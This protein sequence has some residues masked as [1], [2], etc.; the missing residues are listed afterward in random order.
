[1]LPLKNGSYRNHCPYCLF[2]LHV[3]HK[4]G[5]RNN[6]CKGLMRPIGIRHSSKKGIQIV[7]ECTKC[8]IIKV[9]KIADYDMQ[10]DTIDEIIKLMQFAID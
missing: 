6:Q 5:D 3:D 10:S 9:N 8:G 4:P 1:M 7:H 2:S